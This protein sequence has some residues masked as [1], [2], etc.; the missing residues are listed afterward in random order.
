MDSWGNIVVVENGESQRY[1][2][3]WAGCRMLDMLVGGPGLVRRHIA[4]LQRCDG[5]KSTGMYLSCGGGAVIDFDRSR[6]L[7]FGDELM[8]E[9]PHRRALLEVLPEV[10][11]GYRVGWAYGGMSEIA[12]YVGVDLLP[13]EREFVG[14][15]AVARDRHWPCQPV[16]V[17]TSDGTP[18][19][20]R[21]TPY[22]NPASSGPALIDWLPG[23]GSKRVVL[24]TV[25]TS[26]VHIDIPRKALGV[27][28][29]GESGGAFDGLPELWSGWMVENWNDRYEEHVTRCE[30]ALSVPR[31]DL[32][33]GI[34]D[35]RDR[36]RGRLF[37]CRW[38]GPAAEALSLAEALSRV[39]PG[40]AVPAD[41]VLDGLIRPNDDEWDRFVRACDR[42]R[43]SYAR[44]A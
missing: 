22:S 1:Y 32:A 20:W 36:I 34:R 3:D 26:G 2:W 16:S 33:A 11:T 29:I 25:P 12:R 5:A 38:D 4:T 18:R 6:L 35:A 17:V 7:F 40:F 44:S 31:V 13:A 30:G 14:M 24:R 10:W 39:A 15:L 41:A 9:M 28:T 27:W 43:S 8:S 19:I 42:V 37:H 23:R 21:L